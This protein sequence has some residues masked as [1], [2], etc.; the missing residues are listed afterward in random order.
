MSPRPGAEVTIDLDLVR[1]LLADQHPDLASRPLSPLA[2]GRDH[3][4]FRLGRHFVVR[5]PSG[6]LAARLVTH[7]MRWLPEIA[8]LV[9]LPVPVAVRHG[10][11]TA[12]FPWPWSIVRWVEGRPAASSAVAG[13]GRWAGPLARFA[14]QLHQPAPPHHQMSGVSLAERDEITRERLAGCDHPRATEL[15]ALWERLLATPAHHGPPSW[16]HGHL[17]PVHQVV[18]RGNLAAVVGFGALSA[19]DPAC[20]LATAW[21]TF[22]WEGRAAFVV[23]YAE[24]TGRD[25]PLWQRARAWAVSHAAAALAADDPVCTKIA[26]HT[27]T[28]LLD[29]P[30]ARLREAPRAS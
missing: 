13:R 17:H 8:A 16:V 4:R 29:A 24:L 3:A 26:E 19:G 14:A 2:E 7:E 15:T 28:Q 30:D 5:L 27:V 23:R 22:G 25:E 18:H 9:D 6:D 1:R 20:D 10:Q 12:Y 11:P 21:Q